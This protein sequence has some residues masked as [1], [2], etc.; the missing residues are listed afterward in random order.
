[1]QENYNKQ[2]NGF[3]IHKKRI[4]IYKCRV[5]YLVLKH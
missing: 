2:V 4:D 3:G 5:L 1:M